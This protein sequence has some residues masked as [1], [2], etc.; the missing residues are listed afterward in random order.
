MFVLAG[1]FLLPLQTYAS[2]LYALGVGLT[3]DAS[4]TDLV[5]AATTYYDLDGTTNTRFLPA[6]LG[7]SI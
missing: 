6:S 4:T 1:F 2:A 5:A 3:V 7:I